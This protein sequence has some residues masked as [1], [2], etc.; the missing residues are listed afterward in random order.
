MNYRVAGE[1]TAICDSLASTREYDGWIPHGLRLI[2]VQTTKDGRLTV[3]L[4]LIN[5]YAR[6]PTSSDETYRSLF[7]GPPPHRQRNS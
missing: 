3:P 4:V 6:L 5:W 1:C 2:L 7:T